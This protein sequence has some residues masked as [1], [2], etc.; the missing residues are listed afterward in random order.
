MNMT[1][2]QGPSM[3]FANFERPILQTP[4]YQGLPIAA[5]SRAPVYG[6]G[7]DGGDAPA[8]APL[9]EDVV[10]GQAAAPTPPSPAAPVVSSALPSTP[11]WTTVGLALVAGIVLAKIL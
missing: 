10:M 2:I 4:A 11:T 3:G 1:R 6:G 5:G 8:P 7:A 9:P